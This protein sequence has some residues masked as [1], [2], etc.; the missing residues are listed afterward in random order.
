MQNHDKSLLFLPEDFV[1]GMKRMN[2]QQLAGFILK[3]IAP[4]IILSRAGYHALH[5][6]SACISL[7]AA[8]TDEFRR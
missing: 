7:P 3:Q 8:I 1:D 4:D 5:G 2:P 6:R